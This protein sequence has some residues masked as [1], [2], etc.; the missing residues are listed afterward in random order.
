MGIRFRRFH[1]RTVTLRP[2]GR[3]D[4]R[5]YPPGVTLKVAA[6]GSMQYCNADGTPYTART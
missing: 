3:L 1:A 5:A 4:S 6:D 2:I